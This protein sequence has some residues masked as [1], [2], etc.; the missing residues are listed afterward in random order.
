MQITLTLTPEQSEQ[1]GNQVLEE[2]VSPGVARA[3]MEE[4]R[5]I[6]STADK[7]AERVREEQ[8]IITLKPQV[9]EW[10]EN[11]SSISTLRSASKGLRISFVRLR[12]NRTW[13]TPLIEPINQSSVRAV[14][15]EP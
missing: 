7:T 3:Q 9:A 12:K 1:V 11:I 10:K 4:G 8:R 6:Q 5:A 15:H 13:L 2:K 14:Q